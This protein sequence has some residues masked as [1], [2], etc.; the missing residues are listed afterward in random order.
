MNN[1]CSRIHK[2]IEMTK[3]DFQLDMCFSSRLAWARMCDNLCGRVGLSTLARSAGSKKDDYICGYLTETLAQVLEQ[4]V[5]D[6][7]V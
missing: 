2:R 5:T 7:H 1:L 4:F 3:K 6:A